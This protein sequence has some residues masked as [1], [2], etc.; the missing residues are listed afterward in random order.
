M[1]KEHASSDLKFILSPLLLS[2]SPELSLTLLC[3]IDH[4]LSLIHFAFFSL[5]WSTVTFSSV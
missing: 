4:L 3:L 2:G 5:W 1:T